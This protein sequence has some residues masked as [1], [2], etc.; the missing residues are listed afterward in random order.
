MDEAL[1]SALAALPDDEIVKAV[2]Q[3]K[4]RHALA[5]ADFAYVDENGQRH[6]PI[7]D[8]AHVRNALARFNQ[9]TFADA[10]VKA[11]AMTKIRAAAKKFGVD[12]GAD[13]AKGELESPAVLYVEIVKADVFLGVIYGIAS[14]ANLV[15]HEDDVIRPDVLQKAAHEFLANYRA[16][17]DTHTFG[18]LPGDVVESWI[19]GDTWRIAF[20]PADVEIAKAAA[21]GEYVGFS[22]EGEANRVKV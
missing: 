22:V 10:R 11:R 12:G 15:D 19:D 8:A 7:N 14:V 4:D 13:V 18:D 21:R 1:I 16:F 2:L 5:D 6:L 9:T 20:R 17:N 3:A